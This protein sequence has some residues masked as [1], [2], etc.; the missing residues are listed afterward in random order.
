MKEGFII[1]LI[2]KQDLKVLIENGYADASS[3]KGIT[4]ASKNKKSRGKR[5]Y[6]KDAM[7]F[8][9]WHL[10]GLSPEDKDFQIWKEYQEQSRKRKYAHKKREE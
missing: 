7:A 2:S 9:A 6:A 4:I 10:R 3:L 8:T 1:K 5:Y